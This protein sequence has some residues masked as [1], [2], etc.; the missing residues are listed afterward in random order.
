[1]KE[2]RLYCGKTE[3]RCY[4]MTL[5]EAVNEGIQCAIVVVVMVAALVVWS[6]F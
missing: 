3:L 2:D 1:M 5:G 6:F 4:G